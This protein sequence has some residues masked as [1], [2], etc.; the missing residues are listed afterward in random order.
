M[1]CTAANSNIIVF[2][3]TPCPTKE[4]NPTKIPRGPVE[5]F[6]RD[7]ICDLTR[8]IPDDA[9]DGALAAFNPVALSYNVQ[10]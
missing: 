8:V 2:T 10:D 4:S 1:Y 6:C 9:N 5:F 7:S 3:V